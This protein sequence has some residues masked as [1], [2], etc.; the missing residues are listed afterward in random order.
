MSRPLRWLLVTL[1]LCGIAGLV[2]S[3]GGDDDDASTPAGPVEGTELL[4]NSWM[5]LVASDFSNLSAFE[6]P[7]GDQWLAFFHNDVRRAAGDFGK[8][9]TP[10]SASIAER[11]AAGYPCIG[12]ARSHLELAEL[13][14]TAY[15]VERVSVRQL[16]QHRDARSDEVLP[17]THSDYFAG[18]T[19]L[20]SGDRDGATAR[21]SRYAASDA[22][23]PLLKAVALRVSEG[24]IDGDPLVSRIWGA[25]A[26]DAPA[27][28]SL[29]DLPS[30]SAT[31]TGRARLSF[32]IA[33][34]QGDAV[35]ASTMLR[36][37]YAAADLAEELPQVEGE[38]PAVDPV[39]NHR[40]PMFL[41]ALSRYHA[42]QARAAVG[43][44]EELG[45]LAA[46][47][48]WFLGR[49]SEVPQ[50]APSV[51]DGLA[52]IVFSEW[53]T[54]ADLYAAERARPAAVATVKRLAG[55]EPI[56]GTAPSADLSDLDPFVDGS[57]RLTIGLG[58]LL[59][60]SSESGGN[61]DADLGLS[62]RFRSHL[63]RE[64]AVQFQQSFDVQL[65]ADDGADMASAGVAARS[66]LELALDKNPSPPNPELRQA[67]LS[68][69]NDPPLL[70][71]LARAELDTR[72]PGEANDYIRPLTSIY[73]ELIS[74]RDALTILDTAWNP[75][76][77]DGSGVR[78]GN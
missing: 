10:S 73:P 55:A 16:H 6:G 31:A 27:D 13:Y 47:A 15:E 72:R 19:L 75:P 39:M 42:L 35:Q 30:S 21:L 3:C 34:A 44:A 36:L 9:C 8:K 76:T 67:R 74:V 51:V 25:S 60:R 66:L 5:H 28:S 20:L 41:R 69:L 52:L 46:S 1:A 58:E 43:D 70:A 48:D 29:G 50:D 61:L 78:Q 63:L 62:E 65:D 71:A 53:P 14:A 49:P 37:D 18:V 7:T 26:D 59:A 77:K 57:N 33:V 2:V 68:Y 12:L 4:T 24:A 17:S 23:D 64:R 38:A 56:F 22:A 45:V 11:K 40:D 54:P 32:A